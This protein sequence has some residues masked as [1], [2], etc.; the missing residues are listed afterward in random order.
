M[1]LNYIFIIFLAFNVEIAYA[2]IYFD[3]GLNAGK[4][5]AIMQNESE[6]PKV[7]QYG[8][9]STLGHEIYG[10][11]LGV[12]LDYYL[13]EQ[14]SDVKPP[15]GNRRGSRQNIASPTLI[16]NFLS[17][18]LKFDYQFLGFYKFSNKTSAGSLIKYSDPLGM[19]IYL[20]IDSIFIPGELGIFYESIEYSTET[21]GKIKRELTNKFTIKQIGLKISF[22]F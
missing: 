2:S 14:L 6:S 18:T 8:F 7:I 9:G 5:S 15:Y 10:V 1:G 4:G 19:R 22:V 17:V 12:S 16:L 21:Y 13:V 20:G 11:N 3:F